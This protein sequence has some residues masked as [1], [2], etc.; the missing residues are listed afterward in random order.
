MISVGLNC[1]YRQLAGGLDG[2]K[3]PPSYLWK[4]VNCDTE[5]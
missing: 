1:A 3:W 5:G 2:L 4:L